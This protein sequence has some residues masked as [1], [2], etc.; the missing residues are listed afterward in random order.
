MEYER[1]INEDTPRD[2]KWWVVRHVF[3]L[4][5]AVHSVSS[6]TNVYDSKR[7]VPGEARYLIVTVEQLFRARKG[8]FPRLY[9]LLC[10]QCFQT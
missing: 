2:D 1:S 3:P 7:R 10:D 8:H 9:V 5:V 4:T 6:Q